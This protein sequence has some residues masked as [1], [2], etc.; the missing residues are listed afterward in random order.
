MSIFYTITT[1]M[2]IQLLALTLEMKCCALERFVIGFL[3]WFVIGGAI[4]LSVDQELHAARN[5][6]PCLFRDRESFGGIVVYGNHDAGSNFPN[7]R[8]PRR[9]PG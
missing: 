8:T 1:N 4:L 5:R 9:E 2:F 7:W 6:Q 3:V